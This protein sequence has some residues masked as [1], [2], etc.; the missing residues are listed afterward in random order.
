MPDVSDE[1]AADATWEIEGQEPGGDGVERC[2][3]QI[4]VCYS[5]RACENKKQTTQ[6]QC[7]ASNIFV[8]R[9]N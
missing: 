5:V 1:L 3:G 4:P 8:Q 6:A 9:T 2:H 7:L